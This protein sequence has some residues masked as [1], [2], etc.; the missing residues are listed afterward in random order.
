MNYATRDPKD[1]YD[2]QANRLPSN[3]VIAVDTEKLNLAWLLFPQ[4]DTDGVECLPD[5]FVE[6]LRIFMDKETRAALT[7]L[8][9]EFLAYWDK[10]DDG[11][12][13]ITEFFPDN[14]RA[15]MAVRA[16]EAQRR[17]L[18]I[19]ERGNVVRVNFRRKA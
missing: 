12:L 17:L 10:T 14:Y 13:E 5:A 3:S 4:I 8:P 18:G 1:Y 7:L 11:L 19:E 9:N 16:A 2:W 6:A 15:I